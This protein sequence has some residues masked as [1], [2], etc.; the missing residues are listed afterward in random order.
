MT[1]EHTIT[2]QVEVPLVDVFY[3][4]TTMDGTAIEQR[5]DATNAT[6][7]DKKQVS[8]EPA[9]CDA[10]WTRREFD[11]IEESR[12]KIVNVEGGEYGPK[13]FFERTDGKHT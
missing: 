10:M 11:W 12:W 3:E 5:R 13:I 4:E 9:N 7:V 6:A 2:K 8:V 1:S